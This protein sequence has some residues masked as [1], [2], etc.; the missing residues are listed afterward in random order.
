MNRIEKFASELKSYAQK[1]ELKNIYNQIETVKK[2]DDFNVSVAFLG[3]FSSG[4]STLINALIGKKLLP[5]MAKPTTKNI[6]RIIPKKDIENPK[7]FL[8]A[9]DG[10]QEIEPFEFQEFALGKKKGNTIIEIPSSE[11]LPEGFTFIDTPGIS[12]LDKTDID[13]TF[14]CL[15]FIDGAVICQDVNFG[16]FTNSVIKFLKDNLPEELREKFIFAI[17]KVD[18]KPKSEVQQI[19]ENAI[20]TLKKE[21]GYQDAEKRVAICSPLKFLETNDLTFMEDFNKVFKEMIINKK[22]ELVEYRKKK[23]LQDIADTLIN[24]LRTMKDN[25]NLDLSDIESKI[26][27]TNQKISQL[28]EQKEKLNEKLQLLKE[29]L[30]DKYERIL[31]SKISRFKGI[32]SR[33]EA[34]E[35]LNQI[36]TELQEVTQKSIER[37]LKLNLSSQE[38]RIPELHREIESSL[39]QILSIAESI[40]TA[41][42]TLLVVA[43]PGEGE[44]DILQAIAGYLISEAIDESK[45]GKNS[46][47]KKNKN[48]SESKGGSRVKNFFKGLGNLLYKLDVPGKLVDY[49]VKQFIDSK[50]R[51]EFPQMARI[52]AAGIVEEIEE[53]LEES[54]ER[55]DE[56]LRVYENSLSKLHKERLKKL[57]EFQDFISEIKKDMEKIANIK[58]KIDAV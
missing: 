52:M 10:L 21:I 25:S 36:F 50:L 4:K 40:K 14:G 15:P 29:K 53:I 49:G 1:Y 32:T 9:E 46:Q 33:E 20:E 5:A 13:I 51:G 55:I 43:L 31:V 8:E 34:E 6:I 41:L 22:S 23:I 38:I 45:S 56:D 2:K 3:E 24:S 18:T 54:F 26:E 19:R 30:Q 42:R 47:D 7:F 48:P 37:F 27:K 44:I 35:L 12:S 58:E 28:Q 57:D 39:E 11:E 17:T 16:G